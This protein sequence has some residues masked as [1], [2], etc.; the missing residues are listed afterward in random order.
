M[1]NKEYMNDEE[2]LQFIAEIEEHEM[3]SAPSY[4][5]ENILSKANKMQKRA[6]KRQYRAFQLKVCLA[7][8]AAIAV[9]FFI[10]SEL[11]IASHQDKAEPISKEEYF[12]KKN[13]SFSSDLEQF[14]Q[15][16]TGQIVVKEDNRNEKR[17]EK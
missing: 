17:K 16:L 11:Q 1:K 8:A 7:T 12:E 15:K 2:L 5:K 6:V 10:P 14:V 3:V 13:L 4:L 9:I